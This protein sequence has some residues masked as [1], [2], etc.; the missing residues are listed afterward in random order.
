MLWEA[1]QKD[2]GAT[3]AGSGTQDT[4][5]PVEDS[6]IPQVKPDDTTTPAFP[7]DEGS[8]GTDGSVTMVE[9]DVMRLKI[10]QGGTIVFAELPDYPI[11]L[12]KSDQAFVLLNNSTGLYHVIQSG[13]VGETAPTHKDVFSSGRTSYTLNEGEDVLEVPFTWNS[14][15]GVAVTK[16]FVFTPRFL[17]DSPQTHH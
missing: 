12:D 8:A 15:E 5:L 10:D 2:Y 7:R 3:R 17:P 4:T 14:A 16:V 9:T 11:S 6:G 13:I 1:W